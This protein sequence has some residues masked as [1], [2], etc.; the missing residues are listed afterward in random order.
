MMGRGVSPDP[1]VFKYIQTH[2]LEEPARSRFGDF[3]LTAESIRHTGSGRP[4]NAG[5]R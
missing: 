3:W 2:F 5:S 4:P 1:I